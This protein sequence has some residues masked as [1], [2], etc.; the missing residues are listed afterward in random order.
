MNFAHTL[1]AAF[2]WCAVRNAELDA[3]NVGLDTVEEGVFETTARAYILP[4]DT[5]MV[6]M[7][8]SCVC[9]EVSCTK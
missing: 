4:L 6:G 3:L 9:E 8:E 5:G 2:D 1:L 7:N